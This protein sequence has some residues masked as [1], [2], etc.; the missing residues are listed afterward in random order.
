MQFHFCEF[1]TREFFNSHEMFHQFD[2]RCLVAEDGVEGSDIV[3]AEVGLM[4]LLIIRQRAPR[5]LDA[6]LT[7]AI[8]GF[9]QIVKCISQVVRLVF[10]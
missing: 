4:F 3:E 2:S 1:R 9:R 5:S 8:H 10:R 6:P 7:P